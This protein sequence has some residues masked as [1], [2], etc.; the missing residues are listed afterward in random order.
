MVSLEVRSPFLDHEVVEFAAGLPLERKRLNGQQKGLLREYAKR[1]LPADII[2]QPKRGFAPNL[3]LWLRGPWAPLVKELANYSLFVEHE[4][5]D[6]AVVRQVIKE[7]LSGRVDHGQRIW[8]LI[9][10]ETWAKNF[11][12]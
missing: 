3:G 8:N 7:H 1:V 5:F 12:T 4:F 6:E 9:C 11:L 2:H 10:L